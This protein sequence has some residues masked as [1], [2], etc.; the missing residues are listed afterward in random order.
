[1]VRMAGPSAEGRRRRRLST[2]RPAP[3]PRPGRRG[4]S[5]LG[6]GDGL[7]SSGRVPGLEPM[8]R[9]AR[10]LWRN[11]AKN[12]CRPSGDVLTESRRVAPWTADWRG[13]RRDPG[14]ASRGCLDARERTVPFRRNRA[15]PEPAR[16]R[17]AR[18]T[19]TAAGRTAWGSPSRRRSSCPGLAGD[20]GRRRRLRRSAAS[21]G[22]W[23]STTPPTRSAA[24]GPDVLVVLGAR[25]PPADPAQ[26]PRAGRA[27]GLDGH[28]RAGL[29]PHRGPGSP[30]PGEVLAEADRRGPARAGAAAATSGMDEVVSEVLGAVVDQAGRRRS[31]SPPG[32]TTSSSEVALTGG[33][34]AAGRPAARRDARGRR[35]P[36][37]RSRPRG[38]HQRRARRTTSPRSATGCGCSTP[39][40]TTPSPS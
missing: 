28:R 36:R 24:A 8:R 30:V 19:A 3:A 31:P 38:R 37:A 2:P 10:P 22:T 13:T 14:E 35:R 20:R 29:P 11:L 32:W 9:V 23:S 6:R 15:S 1:M 33:G 5:P 17:C 39:P 7:P 40:P 34:L 27:A 16:S 4:R 21:S 12:G 26:L 25:L 18:P